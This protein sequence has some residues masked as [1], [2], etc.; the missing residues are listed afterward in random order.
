VPEKSLKTF[1][2]K[3]Y[4]L[5]STEDLFEEKKFASVAMGFNEH[6][7]AITLYVYQKFQGISYPKFE[8]G[9]ALSLFIDTRDVK[10][11]TYN[12]KFCHNFII[13]PK[14]VDSI[15]AFENTHFRGLETRP[16]VDCT[17]FDIQSKFLKD[18]Y[19]MH[20]FIPAES[21]YGYD[22]NSINH[23][24]FSYTVYRPFD[25]PQNF[26]CSSKDF[27]IEEIPS[28]WASIELKKS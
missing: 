28:L 1:L 14:E 7:L 8:E 15:Q 12:T 18:S 16:L 10:K 20:I 5:P 6:G 4:Y 24:G 3:S 19:Q 2:D 13:F 11:A 22:I 23:I 25:E 17:Q 9:D 27:K 21:L 26:S